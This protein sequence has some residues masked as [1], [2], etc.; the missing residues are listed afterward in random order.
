MCNP[1]SPWNRPP[2]P[3]WPAWPKLAARWKLSHQEEDGDQSP[4]QLIVQQAVGS[5]ARE[6]EGRFSVWTI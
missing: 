2:W 4:G 6:L 1:W 5:F 3:A